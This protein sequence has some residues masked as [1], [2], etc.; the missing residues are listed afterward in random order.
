V[1]PNNRSDAY[2]TERVHAVNEEAERRHAVKQRA[3]ELKRGLLGSTL[4][5]SPERAAA[6]YNEA[7][8]AARDAKRRSAPVLRFCLAVF[9]GALTMLIPISSTCTLHG[10]LSA[11]TLSDG[12]TV[13]RH[14][15]VSAQPAQCQRLSVDEPASVSVDAV[16]GEGPR[17]EAY[18]TRLSPR[19][20]AAC[21]IE[22]QLRARADQ[23]TL[24]REL[25]ADAALVAVF[26]MQPSHWL[27]ALAEKSANDGTL[28]HASNMLRGYG[29]LAW[30]RG[31]ML[32]D[33][34]RH[35]TAVQQHLE[36]LR[37]I[38]APEDQ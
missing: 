15:L 31:L 18:I 28:Q 30:Q 4:R 21:Q 14:A 22:L 32:N 13:D 19:V 23:A 16:G 37:Q 1:Q 12:V 26:D 2:R 9:S 20:G 5:L 25:P 11:A 36:T 6:A 17:F 35:N 7:A 34:V 8:R 3:L 10:Q 27:A 24:L 38:F 33:Y 29:E